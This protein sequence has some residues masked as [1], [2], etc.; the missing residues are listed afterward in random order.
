MILHSSF[1][2]IQLN[3][4]PIIANPHDSSFFILQLHRVPMYTII[5]LIF[6]LI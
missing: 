4:V 5:I 6:V 1:F 3:M 2:N